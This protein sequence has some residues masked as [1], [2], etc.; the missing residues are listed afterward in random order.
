MKFIGLSRTRRGVTLQFCIVLIPL[1]LALFGLLLNQL[2]AAIRQT[3]WEEERL[4]VD[5]MA[6]SA[7]AYASATDGAPV[8]YA[9]S[10]RESFEVKAGEVSEGRGVIECRGTVVVDHPMGGPATF[11]E[12]VTLMR[13]GDSAAPTA[14]TFRITHRARKIAPQPGTPDTGR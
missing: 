14:T 1:S 12:T 9:L 13:I 4:R 6:A 2:D 10:E 3:R 7:V 11:E 5:L 8:R